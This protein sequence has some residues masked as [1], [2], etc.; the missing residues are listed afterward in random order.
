MQDSNEPHASSGIYSIL[1]NKWLVEPTSE[2]HDIDNN[3]I[4]EKG[5]EYMEIIDYLIKEYKN[6]KNVIEDINKV[7]TKLKKFRQGGLEKGGEFSYE[8]LTFKL[9]RRNNYIAKLF[10][11]KKDL[12]DKKLSL[13]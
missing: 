11:L 2:E 6:G 7:Q 3:L 13:D 1:N 10:N 5:D 8:N 9:L 4:L 12:N